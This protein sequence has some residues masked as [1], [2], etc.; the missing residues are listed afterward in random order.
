MIL[1]NIPPEVAGAVFSLVNTIVGLVKAESSEE[2]IEVL[3]KAAED[4][5]AHA[6]AIKFGPK[7]DPE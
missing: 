3:M 7:T 1:D 4:M 5:K 2:R 6:D